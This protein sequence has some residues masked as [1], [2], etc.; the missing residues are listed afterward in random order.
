MESLIDD[1]VLYRREKG[2]FDEERV[3][4]AAADIVVTYLMGKKDID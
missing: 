4:A 1:Y 2:S 3:L